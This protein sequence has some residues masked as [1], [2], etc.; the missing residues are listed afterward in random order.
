MLGLIKK[1]L[2]IIKGNLKLIAIIFVV[3]TIMAIQGEGD[4]S[5][6]PAFI[7]VTLFMST[8]S[9]DEYNNW[10]AYAITL[11]KGRKNIV[12]SKYLA[13]LILIFVSIV[14]TF[15]LSVIVG[16]M[17]HELDIEKISSVM[18]VCSF[19]VILL[20]SI[21]YPLIFK[22][23]IE[24]GR[25]CLFVG[26]FGITGM[27]G[28]AALVAKKFKVSISKNILIFFTHYWMILLPIVMLLV[29][30]VSYKISE[31]IYLKKEF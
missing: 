29:L 31:S 2:L 25:I 7:S 22:L 16:Y 20:Q 21:M 5:F 23:G 4:L 10:N 24:K 8:F 27:T 13:T 6:I 14:M 26:A 17:Q 12:R 19:A 30:L 15:I 9:Y 18:L 1:D 28:I 11:P 3:F